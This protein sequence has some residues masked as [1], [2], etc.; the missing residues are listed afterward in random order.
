MS[1]S[2]VNGVLNISF[3]L[4]GTVTIALLF[5]L[6]GYWIKTKIFALQKF[7]IPAPVVGGFIFVFIHFFIYLSGSAVFKFNA[8]L[9]SVFM[10]AFF[11]SVGLSTSLKILVTGGKLLALYWVVNVFVTILQTGIGVFIGP[12]VGLG[13]LYGIMSGPVALVGGHGGAAAY[14]S[15]LEG[16]GIPALPLLV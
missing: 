4:I 6:L 1:F 10:L 11:T 8:T 12:A 5:L 9:Q 7:C 2:F 14:G 15:T 13:P 16:W 3:D